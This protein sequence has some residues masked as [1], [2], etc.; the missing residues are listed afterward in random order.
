M[1]FSLLQPTPTAGALILVDDDAAL[2]NALSFAFETEGYEVRSFADAETLL[3]DPAAPNGSVCLILDHRLPGMSGL[4][5]LSALRAQAV[6]AP[7]ILITTHP[8]AA[9]RREAAKQGAEIVE[10]PLMGTD[11]ASK[12]R[13]VVEKYRLS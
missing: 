5:L 7:A 8:S 1:R 3:A 4:A 2:L 6:S 13:T 9:V 11:L 12:V 10:K